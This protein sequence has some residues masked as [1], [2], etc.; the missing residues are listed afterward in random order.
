MVFTFSSKGNNLKRTNNP[1]GPTF[2]STNHRILINCGQAFLSANHWILTDCGKTFLSTSH[3]I[4]ID[5]G[6]TFLSTNHW[7]LKNCRQ[8]FLSTNHWIL[9]DWVDNPLN[10]P[11]NPDKMWAIVCLN[12]P[13]YNSYLSADTPLN[14]QLNPDKMW[15]SISPSPTTE[16]I[17]IALPLVPHTTKDTD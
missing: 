9:T 14:Q 10:Q 6:Q 1:S 17:Q 15:V 11:L 7:I 16:S 12:Q 13:L 2:L 8:T 3:W 4:L 5:C